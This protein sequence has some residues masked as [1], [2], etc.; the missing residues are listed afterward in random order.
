[1]ND[2]NYQCSFKKIENINST[3]S[4]IGVE[5]AVQNFHTK[6]ILGLD[7][8][9]DELFQTSREKIMQILQSLLE[10][11]RERNTSLLDLCDKH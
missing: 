7:D 1:M 11:I 10:S 9:A 6:K 5:F 2:A 4:V 3:A 8:F